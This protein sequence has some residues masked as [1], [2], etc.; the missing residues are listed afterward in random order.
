M[1]TS[2]LNIQLVTAAELCRKLEHTGYTVSPDTCE[3]MLAA[4][5]KRLSDWN[6]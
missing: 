3:R 5:R 1:E 4:I 6:Q 2:G